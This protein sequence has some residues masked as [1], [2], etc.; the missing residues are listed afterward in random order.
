MNT[1]FEI[2]FD[3]KVVINKEVLRLVPELGKLSNEE[4]LFIICVEDY[5]SPYRQFPEEERIRK[6]VRNIFHDEKTKIA[7]DPNITALRRLYVGLQY[8]VDVETIKNYT[9]KVYDW[10]EEILVAKEVKRA[11]DLADGVDD[12]NKRIEKIQRRI[13]EAS[14]RRKIQGDGTLSFLE[15]L[16]S[17]IELFKKQD[18][19]KKERKKVTDIA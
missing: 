14:E 10:N 7:T 11:T 8:N 16:H 1:L 17:N 18:K 12:F 9:Q 19:S 15:Q 4:L 13:N 3:N 5:A 2:D 6:S